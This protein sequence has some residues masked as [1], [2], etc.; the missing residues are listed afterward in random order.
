MVPMTGATAIAGPALGQ[1]GPRQDSDDAVYA[2]HARSRAAFDTP[3]PT[4]TVRQLDRD[5]GQMFA[6][7]GRCI[8]NHV[9][10]DH[11]GLRAGS[12]PRHSDLL[13]IDQTDRLTEQS[14]EPCA[15]AAAAGTSGGCCSLA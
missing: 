1:R 6:R 15:T 13:V 10:R 8:D 5:L 14:L 12:R 2:C 11:T 4:N 3:T 9:H 7:V